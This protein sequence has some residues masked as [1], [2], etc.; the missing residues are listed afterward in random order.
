MSTLKTL[1]TN[2]DP[3]EYINAVADPIKRNDSLVL[4]SLFTKITGEKARMWGPS[5][6]G[7][8]MYHYKSE[9]STQEGDWPRTAF[10][11]RK[12]NL[13][14]Y[15]TPGFSDYKTDFSKLGKYK[16]SVGC[17]Y[18]KR[19]SDIN[20]AV[21]EEISTESLAKMQVLYPIK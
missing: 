6:I 18:I 8:G 16:T 10:S 12:Q 1:V 7:F 2:Q 19:L 21:L 4:L 9:R 13:T 17:L 20:I 15:L 14:I 11:P 3:I 5:I